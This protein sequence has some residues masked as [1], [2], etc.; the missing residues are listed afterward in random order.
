MRWARSMAWAS[1]AGF[2]HGSSRKTYSAAVRFRPR[3]PALRLI[4]NSGQSGSSGS[5]RRAPAGRACGRRGTR[6]EP[7]SSSRACS[8]RQQ[9]GE[10]REH[11]RLVALVD[12]LAQLRHSTSSLALGLG[13]ARFGSISPGGRPP[14]AAAAAP[15]A[16]G[17]S[18]P[19]PSRVDAAEQ[20]RGS[21]RAARRRACAARAPARSRA[22]ARSSGQVLR[23]LLLGAPQDER[24][25]PRASSARAPRRAA[26]APRRPSEAARPSMPGLRNSN[27]LHSSP[28]WF[29]TGVPLSASRWRPQQPRRL[30]RLAARVLD[31]LR[32]VEDHVVEGH[33]PSARRC[34]AQRAVGGQ[35][36]V[37]RRSGR[38]GAR[39]RCRCSRARAASARSGRLLLPVEDERARHHDERRRGAAPRRA[40]SRRARAAPAPGRSCPGPCRRPGSRRSRTRGGTR[41]QPSPSRW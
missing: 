34:R 16:P 4:R 25:Q 27:R 24:P 28:R 18:T 26:S 38:A 31:R 3:P 22:S 8:E 17:S 35:D 11:Q 6:R 33:G 23:H 15:R 21:G 9:L 13:G 19:S 12:D 37:V 20:R 36:E 41:S 40:R 2:H 30:R 29:S 32:L 7:A 1:T 10:L 14:G 5:A 39:G